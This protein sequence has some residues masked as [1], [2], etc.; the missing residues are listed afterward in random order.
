MNIPEVFF[1][2]DEFCYDLD[3][4]F[5]YLEEEYGKDIPDDWSDT[6]IEAELQPVFKISIDW[7]MDRINEERFDEEGKPWDKVVNVLNKYIDFDKINEEMPKLY[8]QTRKKV[9]ITK[10]DLIDYVS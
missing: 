7:I 9:V 2:N 1:W 4:I 8:Y 3:K 6:I 10:Q 5:E